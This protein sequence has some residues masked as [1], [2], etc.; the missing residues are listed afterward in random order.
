[1]LF[2]HTVFNN[3]IKQNS[4]TNLQVKTNIKILI[5][6]LIGLIPATF[7]LASDIFIGWDGQRFHPAG[8]GYRIGLALSG[9]GS[10]GLAQV[11]VIRALEEAGLRPKAI[12]GTS[13][14]GIVGGLYAVGFSADSL[15][16][17]IKS[18]NF[19]ALFSDRPSRTSLLLTQRPEKDRYL[20]A[21]RFDGFRPFIPQGLTAGQK[22][23]DLISR[24]TVDAGYISGGSF[25]KLKIP[26]NT[27]TTDIVSGREVVRKKGNLADAIR[28]TMAF[29][30]AFTGVETDGM[31]L[32][33][34][35]MVN[36]IPVD[37]VREIDSDLDLVIAV[38]TTSDL[39]KKEDIKTPIDIANQVTS[40]MTM[41]KREAGLNQADIII[42]PDI[43]EFHSS[44][45][46]QV[47]VL[48]ERGYLAGKKA[49]PEIRQTL[50][51][52]NMIKLYYV[53]GVEL[54]NIPSDFDTSL[55]ELPLSGQYSR[56]DLEEM[57]GQL[58]R[59]QNL[60]SVAFDFVPSGAD[61]SGLRK[62]LLK[63][64]MAPKPKFQ[65]INYNVS[66]AGLIDDTAIIAMLQGGRSHLSSE[67]IVQF[68][69]RLEE[70]YRNAGFDLA[71]VRSLSY[72][73]E[74]HTL[75]INID[76]AIVKKIEIKGTKRTKRWLIRSNF[77]PKEGHPFS[78]REA[79][80]GIANIYNTGLFDR[81]TMNIVPG[82]GGAVVQVGV[83]EKKYT[84]MRFGWHWDDAYHSEEFGEILDDNIFGTGQEFMTYVQYGDQRQ[85]YELSMKADRF[86][87]TY[88]TY[89][90]CGYYE[91][92][93]RK[94]YDG[95]GQSISSVREDRL[96]MEFMLGQQISRF[97]TLTG[98]I[99]WE[100]IKNKY[101][102]TGKIEKQRLRTLTLRSLVETID[103][104]YFPNSG[105][106]HLLF[107]EFA[108]D[109]LGGKAKYTKIFNSIESYFHF[110]G[111][112]N[113]HPKISIGWIDSE[114]PI[115]L[116][117]KFYLGGAY[118]FSGYKTVELTGDK[119]LLGNLELR[120]KLPYR[121][122]LTGRYDLGEVYQ[123]AD[124]IKLRNLR[125]GYGF[126]LAFDSPIGPLDFS[127]GKAKDRIDRYYLNLGLQF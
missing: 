28:A 76:E 85:K 113:F 106:K 59:K 47:E 79:A 38:N 3:S 70:R 20:L 43:E 54:V 115:P 82:E 26:Y 36:P 104:S 31:I 116:S 81:V 118:S 40:I 69:D 122:F 124:Q 98:E 83:D 33:D 112:F 89:R 23:T 126:S 103:R 110:G 21:V 68:S 93:N 65:D 84:Q 39:L 19:G 45:F 10:R 49:I 32:M 56:C 96:G 25:E 11:G 48:I 119:M 44:D 117:E 9:G 16:T 75:A 109:I 114:Y 7:A 24:L 27:V 123:S 34:G 12:A 77:P 102:P 22:L 74:T 18:I 101:R 30:L 46:D 13:I 57:A 42:R 111:R 71:H 86:L 92:L 108:A 66:G 37:V 94:L 125:S 127:Y 17:I 51:Q 41:D 29:P 50:A 15:E 91:I 67:D 5:V 2:L 4:L 62:I 55:I 53:T 87:S 99:R 107:I 120:Y 73:P 121:F 60:F 64:E 95:Q 58:C 63:I 52:S 80:R 78:S 90:A 1:L 88:F 35:G 61:S 14:G 100:D 6:L 72:I 105:K 8:D 97:G